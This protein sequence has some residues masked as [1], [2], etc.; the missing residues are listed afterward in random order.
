LTN[1]ELDAL[2]ELID[3]QPALVDTLFAHPSRNAYL[4]MF[5]ESIVHE[6]LN[7]PRPL[8]QKWAVR[9]SAPEYT[10]SAD[11]STRLEDDWSVD[12]AL[13]ILGPLA[14]LATKASPDHRLY[15]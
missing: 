10:H 9:M 1:V 2:G 3:G 5:R 12:D 4:Q 15:L 6:L 11:G 8:A 7:A 14:E 13:N